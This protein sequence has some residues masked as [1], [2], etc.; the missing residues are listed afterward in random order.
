MILVSLFGGLGNQ[1]FQYAAAKALS[2]KHG[3]ELKL[4][5][6]I[7]ENRSRKENFTF[8]DFELDIFNIK[9]SVATPKEVSRFVPDLWHSPEYVKQFYKVKRL[10]TGTSLYREKTYFSFDKTLVNLHDNTYLYGY[11]QSQ[12]YFI[13]QEH[14]IRNCFRLKKELDTHNEAFLAEMQTSNSV[15][16]H[17]RRGDYE[18]SIFELLS[19]ENYYLPAINLIR[20]QITNPKFYFFTNDLEW[21][22]NAFAELN[23]DKTYV[24]HNTG[25]ESFKDMILM[26][27][28]KHHIIANSSFSWWGAWLNPSADKTVIAPSIW[29]Q[30]GRHAHSTGNL[31]PTNWIKI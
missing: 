27:K 1:M 30:S 5:T 31:I 26:S 9:E 19:F 8:R 20:N 12:D 3:F 21:T 2:S 25:K 14:L 13:G 23:I 7:L 10:F 6:T 28:C 18:N 29:F 24:T 4:D 17:I 22:R 11:F 15:S 16:V